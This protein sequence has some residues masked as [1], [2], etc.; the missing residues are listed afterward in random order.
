ML[1]LAG[2]SVSALELVAFVSGLLCVWLTQ[3]MHIANWPMGMF[4]AVCFAV[5]F[6]EAKLYADA[7][8]QA[9]FFLL[10]AYGW[11]SWVR[12]KAAAG[13]LPVTRA[14]L[15][16]VG[17]I[18][19]LALVSTGAAASTLMTWTDSPAPWP[20]ATVLVL[21]LLATWA[22]ARRRIESWVL[23]I[24]VDVISIPLYWSRS[25]PLTAVLY[26]IFLALCIAGL[27]SWGK[28]LVPAGAAA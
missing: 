25:L 9:A 14:S 4:N 20:D 17:L 6:V 5:L 21:S 15:P 13:S 28:R 24:V 22:Q 8:L 18:V 3:R 10:G 23:W 26:V 12:T 19:L 27:L 16:E 2:Q 1:T 11:W 7:L